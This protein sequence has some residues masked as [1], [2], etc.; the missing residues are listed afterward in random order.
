MSLAACQVFIAERRSRCSHETS[1]AISV[2]P[3]YQS[4][5]QALLN[6]GGMTEILTDIDKPGETR[7]AEE[8]TWDTAG[9]CT[10]L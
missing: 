10:T 8:I 2:S 7:L 5:D 3:A 1:L 6:A 4:I 9:P